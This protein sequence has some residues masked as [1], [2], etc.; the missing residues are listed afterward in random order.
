MSKRN[1]RIKIRRRSRD[2]SRV[3]FY[4]GIK[5]DGA[6]RGWTMQD[7]LYTAFVGFIFLLASYAVL[8]CLMEFDFGFGK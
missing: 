8:Q 2:K 5:S 3:L 4:A 6:P 1:R 7:V